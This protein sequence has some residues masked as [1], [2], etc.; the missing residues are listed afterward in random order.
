MFKNEH[1]DKASSVPNATSVVAIGGSAG[2]IEALK[3][4]LPALPEDL[5]AAIVIALHLPPGGRHCSLLPKILAYTTRLPV[6]WARH[7]EPLCRGRIYVAPQDAHTT[8]S[9]AGT[10]CVSNSDQRPSP[11]VDRLFI[12]VALTYGTRAIGIVLSGWLT[13][14]AAGARRIAQ[15]GGRIVVQDRATSNRFEMP[16][17]ALRMGIGALVLP[18][19]VIAAALT[20]M[21]MARGAR[22]WFQP[23]HVSPYVLSAMDGRGAAG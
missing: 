17:A 8:V 15:A 20:M 12:S 16:H 19:P 7:G 6:E 23:E 18:A 9:A 10:F 3:A 22:E 14:G 5:P 21:L 2:G 13:D 4:M 1:S 11:S